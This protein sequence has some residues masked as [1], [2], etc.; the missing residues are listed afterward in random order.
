MLAHSAHAVELLML[1]GD[2]DNP[3]DVYLC[4][5]LSGMVSLRLK[6]LAIDAVL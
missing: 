5:S 4:V 3:A 6:N 1:P 2:S